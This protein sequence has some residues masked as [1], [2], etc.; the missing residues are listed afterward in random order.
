MK[1]AV[2]QI[3]PVVG[4]I[5][6]NGRIIARC[7][8]EAK[9]EG[10]DLIVFPQLAALG[11]PPQDLLFSQEIIDRVQ[12]CL[13]EVVQ[14]ASQ[15][16]G[17]ILGAPVSDMAGRRY[18]SALYYYG[19][20]LLGRHD[21]EEG[22]LSEACGGSLFVLCGQKIGVAICRDAWNENNFLGE[23]GS[24]GNP[25]SWLSAQ[26][27]DV[28]IIIAASPYYYGKRKLRGDM[29][30]ATAKKYGKTIVYVNQAGGNDDLIFDGSSLIIG[31]DGRIIWQ[32][33]AF[34]EDFAVIPLPNRSLCDFEVREG[35]ESIYNALVL[36]I[37]DYVRKTGF[38]KAVIGLSG[39]I[40]SAVVA[41]LAVEALGHDNV[42]GVA[43]P[44]RYSSRAS[45]EDARGLAQNLGIQLREISIEGIFTKMISELN[46]TD[47]LL[48]DIAE[49][50]LQARIRS[51]ILMFISNRQGHLV[52]STG[53]KSEMAVGYSTLYGD[54]S[55]GLCPLGDVPKTTVYELAGYINRM[56]EV[57][58]ASTMLKPPSAELRPNQTDEDSLPPYEVLDVLLKAYIE[59]NLS[60]EEIAKGGYDL[61]LVRDI[62][63]K[64][65]K[66][67][68]KRRQAP[69]VLRV[70]DKT[71]GRGRCYPIAW[72]RGKWT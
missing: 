24:G 52:L 12:Y 4:D 53:N 31:A 55:G 23:V 42:L 57:I 68:Y 15:G 44:S 69:L 54:M 66:A 29:L 26:G 8:E 11:Y 56:K 72:R 7:I 43:M 13:A 5:A 19:G 30:T 47:L 21:K 51:N 14:P 18:N 36:G 39:G 64:V 71:F 32:G 27:A 62:I 48:Q 9:R 25:A 58:P 41:A 45:L 1:V 37:K 3:N 10:A 60:V 20:S 2:G 49:E 61:T 70:T 17:I 16:I 35:I 22:C 65:D 28:L 38:S 59:D 6:Y 34:E 46:E 67:E 50:N 40:D 63:D 33:R